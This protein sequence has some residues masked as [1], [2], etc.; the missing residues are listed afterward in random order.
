MDPNQGTAESDIKS[1]DS[2]MDR[3]IK[4]K[5]S[6]ACLPSTENVDSQS[7]TTSSQGRRKRSSAYAITGSSNNLGPDTSQ[8]RKSVSRSMSP[9]RFDSRNVPPNGSDPRKLS[10]TGSDKQKRSSVP[11][12]ERKT[13][14]ERS[15]GINIEEESELE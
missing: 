4:K 3:R 14:K 8:S 12:S 1:R 2:A 7:N 5:N 13:S 6:S 10:D 11:K 9:S 15:C